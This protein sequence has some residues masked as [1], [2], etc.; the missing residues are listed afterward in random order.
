MLK[1]MRF[2]MRY[3]GVILVAIEFVETVT[4]D[5][6]SGE[7]KKMMVLEAVLETLKNVGIAPT[8]FTITLISSAID[9]MVSVLNA[10]SWGD[11]LE[12]EANLEADLKARI[13][14]ETKRVTAE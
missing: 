11:K 10:V 1:V 12:P 5:Q 3:W 6:T 9:M 8:R 13:K 4:D 7:T 2:V 14:S